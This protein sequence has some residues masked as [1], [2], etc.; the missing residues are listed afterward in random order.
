M[1]A[2]LPI[3]RSIAILALASAALAAE[4]PKAA[5]RAAPRAAPAA[6]TP[7]HKAKWEDFRILTDRNIF[8]RN[9]RPQV[10]RATRVEPPRGP[11]TPP[12]PP[13]PIDDDQY[14]VL[15]GIG[16]EGPQYTAFFEDSKAGKILQVSPGDIVGKGRLRAVN[17]DSVQ[18]DR[19]GKSSIVKVG[20]T[21]TGV[22]AASMVFVAPAPIA[23]PAATGTSRAAAPTPTPAGTT[24]TAGTA[25]TQPTTAPSA[26][27]APAPAPNENQDIIERMRQ[28]RLQE[29]GR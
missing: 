16:L 13:K 1:I 22:Q 12:Q 18:Y 23:G 29:L 2:K 24:P 15:L 20:Y 17:L 19:G 4:P 7:T 26:G 25:T 14:L 28:R 6:A 5:P 10:A 11:Y 9:R 8:D 27:V 21:L 3:L